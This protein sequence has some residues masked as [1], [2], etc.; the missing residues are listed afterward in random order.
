MFTNKLKKLEQTSP[1]VNESLASYGD[2]VCGCKPLDSLSTGAI[3]S[4]LEVGHHFEQD[5]KPK[6][7]TKNPSLQEEDEE[8]GDK[9][10][11]LNLSG[12][13]PKAYD[14][15]NVNGIVRGR[16]TVIKNPVSIVVPIDPREYLVNSSEQV[17]SG[18]GNI[19]AAKV[20]VCKTA[21]MNN[22]STSS[23]LNRLNLQLGSSV[24]GN[25]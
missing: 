25:C 1:Y 20:N 16:N 7:M 24:G 9:S 2:I 5:E 12:D 15:A 18:S 14:S 23:L 8:D 11:S 10:Q 17:K 4:P 3:N 19:E 13:S 6:D 21:L 22:N